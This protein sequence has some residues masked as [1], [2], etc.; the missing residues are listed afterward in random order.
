MQK[1][2]VIAYSSRLLKAY[3]TRL[4]KTHERNYPTHDL[5]L[6]LWCLCLIHG[7]IIF[8]WFIVRSSLTIRV[9]NTSLVI[10]V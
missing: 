10:G 9:L 1:E 3:F 4:L 6:H 8:M 2:K 5:E 7:G